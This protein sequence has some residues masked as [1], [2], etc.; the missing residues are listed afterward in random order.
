MTEEKRHRRLDEIRNMT[1][2]HREEWV[3]KADLELSGAIRRVLALMGGTMARPDLS[4][5]LR[6]DHEVAIRLLRLYL[7]RL[8]AHDLDDPGG[9]PGK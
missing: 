2:G 8:S 1:P 9:Y 5:E 6:D 4:P 7:E 3:A